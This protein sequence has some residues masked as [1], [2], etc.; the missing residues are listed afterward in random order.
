MWIRINHQ[1]GVSKACASVGWKS[2][3]NWKVF[4]GKK[5]LY[6]KNRNLRHAKKL[7]TLYVKNS[8][9]YAIGIIIWFE[10]IQFF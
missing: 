9:C 5:L 4:I 7:G 8:L 1:T 3:V 6:R 10:S 2:F